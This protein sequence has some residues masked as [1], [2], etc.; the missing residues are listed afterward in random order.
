MR[1]KISSVTAL[2][3]GESVLKESLVFQG[4]AGDKYL[5]ISFIIYLIKTDSR[6]ILVDAGC[7]TMPGFEMRNYYRPVEVLSRYGI[8]AEEITDVVITH[9]HHDHIAAVHYFKNAVIHIQQEEYERGKKYIPE[10]FM[11]NCFQDGYVIDDCMNIVKIGGHST[12]SCIVTFVKDWEEYIIVG[13]ECY[14]RACL[15]MK[16]PTGASCCLQKSKEFIEKYSDPKYKIL[17]CHGD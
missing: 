16:I 10:D 6:T 3:Y 17:L 2:K 4:G 15:E 13:D 12:G 5:P 14:A 8:C 11:V 9:A 7:D 1:E